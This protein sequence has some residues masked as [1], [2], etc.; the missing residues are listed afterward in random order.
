MND[1][2]DDFVEKFSALGEG[3][4]SLR[5]LQHA[6]AVEREAAL[7]A[8]RRHQQGSRSSPPAPSSLFY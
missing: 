5:S 6:I 4:E 3:G 8:K 2:M 7:D 1:Y